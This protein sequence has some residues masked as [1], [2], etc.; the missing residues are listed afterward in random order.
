MKVILLKDVKNIGKAWDIKEVSAGYARNFLFPHNLA[1]TATTDLI[2]K[3]EAKKA[4]VIKKAE[5]DLEK[6]EQLAGEL[7]D[8][9]IKIKA[10]ANAEG[11]L[12]GSIKPD[13]IL[14][15]LKN[16][17]VNIEKL[18]SKS[19]STEAIKEIGEHKVIINLPHGLEAVIVV[20][21]EKE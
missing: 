1:Q 21:V 18:P 4:E 15:A 13:M 16:E 19:I 14:E 3:S 10:K 7:D 8:F 2:K 20:I 12:F 17:K 5:A 9:V 11:K 6:I